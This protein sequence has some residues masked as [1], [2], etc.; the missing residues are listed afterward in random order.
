[1][2]VHLLAA[3]VAT[4]L[5]GWVLTAIN[6][7]MLG[8]NFYLYITRKQITPGELNGRLADQKEQFNLRISDL[9]ES[10]K[11]TL[12][13]IETARAQAIERLT[14]T[15]ATETARAD[16]ERQKAEDA[17]EVVAKEVTPALKQSNHL[18]ER[19]TDKLADR[20]HLPPGGG[21]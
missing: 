16:A 3:E 15:L 4:E 19:F 8:V 7:G 13:A 20:A 9:Q 11:Q 6:T 10:H 17:F 21:S 2:L 18:I 5:P 1:M 12:A 14:L